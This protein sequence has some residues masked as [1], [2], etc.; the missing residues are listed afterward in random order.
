MSNKKT[1]YI[2][3]NVEDE[4][5]QIDYLGVK[6][7]YTNL[8]EMY[9]S[10]VNKRWEDKEGEPLKQKQHSQGFNA[11]E[12]WQVVEW[13]FNKY[14]YSIEAELNIPESGENNGCYVFNGL[15]KGSQDFK[16]ELFYKSNDYPTREKALSDAISHFLTTMI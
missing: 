13:I 10:T 14:K 15:I 11:F 8:G 9:Y 4:L 5:P 1:I 12:Q 16:L 6:S 3:I 7:F 2:P